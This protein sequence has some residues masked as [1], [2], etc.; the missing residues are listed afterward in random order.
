[1]AEKDCTKCGLAKDLAEYNRRASSPDGHRSECRACQRVYTKSYNAAT[2]KAAPEVCA[3]CGGPLQ[4]GS[5]R[6]VC[7]RNPEC[8][9]RNVSLSNRAKRVKKGILPRPCAACAT[10]FLRRKGWGRNDKLCPGC[11][12]DRFW[13][14]GPFNVPGHIA[15]RG[16]RVNV[17]LCRACRLVRHA[18]TRADLMGIP[19]D[20]TWQ[21]VESVFPETCPYLGLSLSFGVGIQHAAS[22]SLDRVEPAKGYVQG[23]VEVISYLA[24]AMK[25]NATPDQLL[26]FADAVFR[27]FG[28]VTAG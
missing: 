1:M 25:S 28:Q 22:P 17:A 16:R 10:P 6:G 21:Y 8:K 13:C 4:R 11:S 9:R 23:N 5:R 26:A 14:V 20:L 3:V 27:K 24:N 7:R 15:P 12:V 19:F 2:G 18:Q